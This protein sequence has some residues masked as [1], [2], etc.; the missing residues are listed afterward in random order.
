MKNLIIIVT[1]EQH[2]KFKRAALQ[3]GISLSNLVR[4]QLG[5]PVVKMGK[6]K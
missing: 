5:L 3:Q 1:P 2:A 4:S 6:K